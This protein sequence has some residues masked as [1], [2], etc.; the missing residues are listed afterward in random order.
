MNHPR[1]HELGI[2][3]GRNTVFHGCLY[4]MRRSPATG[5]N[6]AVQQQG[7]TS[8]DVRIGKAN[9]AANILPEPR[10]LVRERLPRQKHID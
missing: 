2:A 4:P 7:S 10:Q 5:I 1:R 8:F 6:H 3:P 9:N